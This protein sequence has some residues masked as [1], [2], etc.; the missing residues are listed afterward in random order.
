MSDHAGHVAEYRAVTNAPNDQQLWMAFAWG[1][2]G[3]RE[4]KGERDNPRIVAYHAVTSLA[5]P[6]DETSW[7]SSF[8]CWCVAQAGGRHPASARARDWL[9]D[10][11]RPV[12]VPQLGAL[13]VFRRGSGR[14]AAGP[15][16]RRAP[17]HSGFV[18]GWTGGSL[19]ILGGNQSDSVCVRLYPRSRLLG[20]VIPG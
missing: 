1:E 19:A 16:V 2:L 17:S 6:D 8:A 14:G 10:D 15:S 20:M 13:A 12:T 5:A 7:C 11:L 3:E 18:V 9:W 4:V